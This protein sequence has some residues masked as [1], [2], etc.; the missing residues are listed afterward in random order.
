MCEFPVESAWGVLGQKRDAKDVV[1]FFF[2][3]RKR[4]GN[5]KSFFGLFV[6]LCVLVFLCFMEVVFLF[7]RVSAK[8]RVF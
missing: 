6:F 1:G 3:A 7:S 8:K 4:E 5:K 2:F